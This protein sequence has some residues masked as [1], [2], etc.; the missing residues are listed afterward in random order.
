MKK[1]TI[2]L[3][4]VAFAGSLGFTSCKKCSTCNVKDRTTGVQIATSGEFCG[5][6][7]YVKTTEESFETTWSPYGD[8][9]CN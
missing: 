8:V 4:A 6:P 2:I 7:A 5:T 3:I 9:S 1:V